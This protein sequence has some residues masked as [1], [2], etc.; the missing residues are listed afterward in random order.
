MKQ[1][2]ILSVCVLF[3]SCGSSTNERGIASVS[4][5]PKASGS[6]Y[7][8]SD[9]MA[10]PAKPSASTAVGSPAVMPAKNTADTLATATTTSKTTPVIAT[11]PATATAKPAA[12]DNSADVKKGE[13]LISKSD[14]LACHKL[15]DRLVGPSYKE[16]ANKYPNN[17]ATI[18]QLA[19]KIKKG[20]S[21]VWGA[22]PM[23]PHPTLSDDDAKAMVKYI[24]SLK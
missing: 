24:L 21:G 19:G 12:A 13:V 9:T 3:I 7:K 15:Q 20:G 22:I 5:D 2:L 18:S 14:C 11:K 4:N 6:A 16:V 10:S 1:I 23:S 17:D 8:I